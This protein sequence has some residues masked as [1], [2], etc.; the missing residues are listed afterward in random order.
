MFLL[1]RSD[2]PTK[3]FMV[4]V[5]AGNKVKTIYFGAAGYED[6]TIHK[7]PERMKRYVQRHASR[8]DW[9]S[10]GVMT[11]GW[12]SR[13]LLWNKPSLQASLTDLRSKLPGNLVARL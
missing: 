13:W 2:K 5:V 3:K 6:Y 8:E 10:S 4:S 12:W 7:D 9:S 11:P 1:Q